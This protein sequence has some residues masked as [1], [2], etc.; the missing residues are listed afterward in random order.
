MMGCLCRSSSAKSIESAGIVGTAEKSFLSQTKEQE[1]EA[2]VPNLD[3][4]DAEID[5]YKVNIITIG[6]LVET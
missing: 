3:E 6:N 1:E 2:V 5:I 4:F